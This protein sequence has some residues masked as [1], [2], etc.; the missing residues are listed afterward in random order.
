MAVGFRRCSAEPLE[1][2]RADTY[3]TRLTRCHDPVP[4]ARPAQGIAPGTVHAETAEV[5][6][7]PRRGAYGYGCVLNVPVGGH[8]E[9]RFRFW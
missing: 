8:G 1:R 9:N 4:N 2:R 5:M 7:R 3:G 6:D